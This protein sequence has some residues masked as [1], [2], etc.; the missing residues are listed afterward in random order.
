MIWDPSSYD[1]DTLVHDLL[2][3]LDR[4]DQN[5]PSMDDKDMWLIAET[6]MK[7][8]AFTVVV[9]G[10]YPDLVADLADQM[11]ERAANLMYLW[12]DVSMPKNGWPDEL[13]ERLY[14]DQNYQQSN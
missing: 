9:S 1:C 2:E 12:S 11:S 6:L 4:I 3:M 14:A 10:K 13:L 5:T 8:Y 7:V